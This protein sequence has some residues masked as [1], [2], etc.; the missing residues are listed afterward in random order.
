MMIAERRDRP[1]MEDIASVVL[2]IQ[3]QDASISCLACSGFLAQFT[4]KQKT[5][6]DRKKLE[7]RGGE[8]KK[9]GKVL[10]PDSGS[11]NWLTV[12]IE[13]AYKS[14]VEPA[15]SLSQTSGPRPSLS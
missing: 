4:N 2:K 6:V 1:S 15:P 13:L 9:D 7:D 5:T 14:K 8:T 12:F 10:P 3:R 11:V